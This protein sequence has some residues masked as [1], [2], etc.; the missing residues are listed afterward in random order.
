MLTF[1]TD[2]DRLEKHLL[3]FSPTDA[4]KIK[5]FINAIRICLAFDTPSKDTPFG[6]KAD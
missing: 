5:E 6:G 1:Y 4:G 3:E 2:V